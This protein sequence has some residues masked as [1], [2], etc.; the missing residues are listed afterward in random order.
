MLAAGLQGLGQP[1]FRAGQVF[2]WLHQKLATG[3]EEMSNL[4]ASL[5]LQLAEHCAVAAPSIKQKLTSQDGTLKYLLELADGNCIETVLMRYRHG[6]TLCVSSQVGCRMGCRFCASTQGGLVRGLTA[7][8]IAGQVYAVRRDTGEAVSHVVLMGIG[9]PLDNFDTVMDFIS[10]ITDARGQN[11]SGR[12][13]TLSTCGLVPMIHRLAEEKLPITLSV[14]LHAADDKKRS[15]MMPVNEAY[16]V[17]ELLAACRAYRAATGRRVSFEYAMV[18]GVNDSDAD[19]VLLAERLAGMDAHINLIP[20]NP[21]DGTPY[22]PSDSRAVQHFQSSLQRLGLNATVRR[23]LG[24]D[25]NA[26]CGQLRRQ[27]ERRHQ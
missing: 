21:V 25:I 6:N 26:A 12:G 20:V 5:R 13:I 15:A 22:G 9:E 23:R 7:G 4:P 11:L 16:G 19:A 24:A 14:S 3:F 10:I 27:E 2:S 17:E 1:A 18:R 8:E